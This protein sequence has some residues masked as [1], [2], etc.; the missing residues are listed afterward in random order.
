M[1][2]GGPSSF[3]LD[4][5]EPKNQAK[6]NLPPTRQ[7]TLARF[8]GRP[9][10][11]F[12]LGG[13]NVYVLINSKGI[14]Q[15]VSFGRN[16]V[17]QWWVVRLQG[18]IRARD[19]RIAYAKLRAVV[20]IQASIRMQ[21]ERS[22]FDLIKAAKMIKRNFRTFVLRRF[23]REMAQI[24]KGAS[25]ANQWGRGFAE[26]WPK[27][28]QLAAA[29]EAE[30]RGL[31][32]MEATWRSRRLLQSIKG[33]EVVYRDKVLAYDLFRNQKSWEPNA[34][35]GDHS[36]LSSE[37]NPSRVDFELA[38]HKLG[39]DTKVYFSDL[40]DKM[41]PDGKMVE[42]AILLTDKGF[43]RMTPGKYKPDKHNELSD[44]K[45]ISMTKQND[46]VVVLHHQGSRDS[47]INFGAVIGSLKKPQLRRTRSY[48]DIGGKRRSSLLL[49][50]EADLSAGVR[51]RSPSS[52]ASAVIP[53][54]VKKEGDDEAE[55]CSEFVTQV[56]MA[57]RDAKLP[58][59][60]VTFNNEIQVNVA[61]KGEP[62]LVLIRAVPN[63]E[64]PNSFW[65]TGKTE[66]IVYCSK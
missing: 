12:V 37:L 11:A 8:F 26:R 40:V 54:E 53:A 57:I 38:Y 43:Y 9:L 31:R 48:S 25:R 58:A 50:P 66:H 62:K 13:V 27:L 63:K 14:R 16:Q 33:R 36:Y 21:H 32:R 44:I 19:V 22:L 17:K 4:E 45:G 39:G 3:S 1:A 59:P 29:G 56:I 24:Y 60:T 23:F 20:T 15:Q 42:R 46:N 49:D 2:A 6:K 61:K 5:K 35:W 65:E 7:N 47:V 10:P 18:I 55:R 34:V 30:T 28:P 64:M 52:A 41:N 51:D